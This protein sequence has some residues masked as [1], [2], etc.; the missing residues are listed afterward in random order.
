MFYN[1]GSAVITCCMLLQ[2]RVEVPGKCKCKQQHGVAVSL[3]PVTTVNE[4]FSLRL[5]EAHLGYD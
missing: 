2:C 1:S 5:Q 3:S 4:E